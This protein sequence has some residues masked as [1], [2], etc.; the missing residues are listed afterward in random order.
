MN[1]T[2]IIGYFD[3]IAE[4]RIADPHWDNSGRIYTLAIK[5]DEAQGY[6]EG[7]LNKYYESSDSAYFIQTIRG[8]YSRGA[9]ISVIFDE[10]DLSFVINDDVW[11]LDE[12]ES[13]AL[14]IS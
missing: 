12:W 10:E 5:L 11:K 7:Y 8:V 2:V 1:D 4:G 6:Y 14:H 13:N 3:A 9:D